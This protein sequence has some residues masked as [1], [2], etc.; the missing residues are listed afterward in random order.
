M[1][2]LEAEEAYY[3]AVAHGALGRADLEGKVGDSVAVRRDPL[4][5]PGPGPGRAAEDE[6]RASRLQ[7]VHRLVRVPGLRATVRGPPHA[8]PGRVVVRRL[9][10]VSDREHHGVH[11]DD[12]KVV[13]CWRTHVVRMRTVFQ[14]AQPAV[15]RLVNLSINAERMM[16][17]L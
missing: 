12:R 11:A 1:R 15:F 2:R 3:Y 16:V 17:S 14:T 7:D 8:E 5:Q 6:P 9:L 10:R 4:A 13:H